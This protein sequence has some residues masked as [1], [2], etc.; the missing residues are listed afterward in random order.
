MNTSNTMTD[1]NSRGS[2]SMTNLKTKKYQHSD[3]FA[4]VS[5]AA[6]CISPV[7]PLE[8]F[9][10]CNP[11]QGF[12]HLPFEEALLEGKRLFG[13]AHAIPK[14]EAVNRELIKWCGVFLDMGQGSIEAPNRHKGFYAAFLSLSIYDRSLH[15]GSKPVKDWL[16]KLPAQAEEAIE[17]CLEK[18]GVSDE[19][20]ESFLKE[21]FAYLPGWAGYVKWRSVWKN[22]SSEIDACPVT[23]VEFIAVRL[24]ITVALWPQACLE[25]KNSNQAQQSIDEMVERIKKSE[26]IYQ[27]KLIKQ[28]IPQIKNIDSNKVRSEAQLVF[29]IDVRSEPFRRNLE[30][31]G[32]YETLGFAGFFGIP[33]RIHDFNSGTQKDS[34]PVLL[35]PKYD[36]QEK[37]LASALSCV[38]KSEDGKRTLRGLKNVYQDLKYNFSTPFALVETLGPW[39]GIAML[40]KTIAP[41]VT[42]KVFKGVRNH[43]SPV[44]HTQPVIQM[45][46]NNSLYGISPAE[47]ALYGEAV[48]KIMGLTH[49]FAKMV[50]FCGHRSTTENNP[51]ASAL[52]CGACGGNHGGSNAKILAAILNTKS[53]RHTLSE[54]GIVIP[55]DTVFYAAEHDTTTDEVS[56]Y[57]SEF[58]NQS[59]HDLLHNLKRNLSL[60]KNKNS[61]ARCQTFGITKTSNPTK[62]TL[63]RSSDWAEVR[64]EWGLA[65][66]AAFIIGP[67]ELTQHINLE[68]RSFLHNYNWKQDEDGCSIETI[69]TAPMVVTQWINTQYLFSTLNNVSYG[70]GSKIT[71]NVTGQL[72]IMQG[73]GSDLMHGLPLQSVNISDNQAYHEPQRLLTIVYAPREKIEMIIARQEILKTLFFNGWVTLVVIEPKEEVA[74]QL[75]RQGNWHSIK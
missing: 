47:Q 8:T 12:E 49:N 44:L 33:A 27:D 39:S 58:F 6:K 50:V 68:G 3:I 41:N 43:L 56:I 72:G 28:L 70:S 10:A 20:Y 36:I 25:K 62:T 51:Y 42:N 37:P 52:D 63:T 69:L 34:C 64:P 17:I 48:L 5:N 45:E 14:L 67:R 59:H 71:H 9:I 35:K 38:K 26:Q 46:K 30:P 16:A 32:A 74:Y 60:A 7:W 65:R 40:A 55:E 19:N 15:L 2:E 73:N 23:L 11:L 29:C 54:R 22:P 31:L 4:L 24:A 66:N 1:K 75:D 53:V 57:E 61:I 13:S 21:S 18:L